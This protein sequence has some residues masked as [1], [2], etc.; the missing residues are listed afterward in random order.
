LAG[1][2]PRAR[3]PSAVSVVERGRG[4]TPDETGEYPHGS[5]AT[6]VSWN[7]GAA[8]FGLGRAEARGLMWK[9][10]CVGAPPG[11]RGSLTFSLPRPARQAIMMV[12]SPIM[13]DM[14]RRFLQCLSSKWKT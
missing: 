2:D 7:R 5:G 6:V 9:V 3:R 11:L 10:K 4:Q 12:D 8:G 13:A 14:R 1:T